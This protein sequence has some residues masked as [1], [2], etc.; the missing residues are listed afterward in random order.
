M[1]KV[2]EKE[3]LFQTIFLVVVVLLKPTIG[4][5]FGEYEN[6]AFVFGAFAGFYLIHFLFVFFYKDEY[7]EKDHWE[8]KLNLWTMLFYGLCLLL[9]HWLRVQN[10]WVMALVGVIL[11]AINVLIKSKRKAALNRN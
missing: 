6:I 11:I 2:K 5:I 10:V 1:K 7:P 8:E 3:N 9:L 4:A